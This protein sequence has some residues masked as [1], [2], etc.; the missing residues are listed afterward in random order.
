MN[1]A[2]LCIALLFMVGQIAAQDHFWDFNEGRGRV[3]RDSIGAPRGRNRVN[4]YLSNAYWRELDIGYAVGITGNDN[5]YVTFGNSIGQFGR[6]DFTVAFWVR[7]RE[8]LDLYDLIGNRAD[9]SYG[10]YFN[11]RMN[12]EGS[13]T[14]E[15]CEDE[16]GTNYMGIRAVQKGLNDGE[17][18]HIAVVRN[19]GTLSLYIDGQFSIYGTNRQVTNIRNNNPF[20]I[21]R[22]L[23]DR[24]TRRFAPNALFDDLAI[25]SDDLSPNQIQALYRDGLN[26]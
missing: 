22:S 4:G 14:A 11:V 5:S 26:N 25:Y 20:K 10:N 6:E 16:R 17:W 12:S 15:I 18:H 7:T 9:I 2:I 19:G 21:G 24:R 1:K 8:R 23:V 13:V 3:A